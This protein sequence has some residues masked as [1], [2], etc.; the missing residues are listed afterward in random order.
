MSLYWTSV[1]IIILKIT[2]ILHYGNLVCSLLAI[3]DLSYMFELSV[4]FEKQKIISLL[5]LTKGFFFCSSSTR[6]LDK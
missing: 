4:Y 1:Y 2:F 6:V 5:L 3:Q